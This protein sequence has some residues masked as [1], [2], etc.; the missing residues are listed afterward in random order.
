MIKYT[1]EFNESEIKMEIYLDNAAT[2]KMK[3]EGINVMVQAMEK[4]Y[5]NSSSI[6]SKGREAEDALENAR[7]SLAKIIGATRDE[8][9]F[10]SG[11][12]EGNNQ[13]IKNYGKSG[14]H[15]VTTLVEH[16]SVLLSMKE[17]ER[18]GAEVDYLDV[19][20]K[21]HIS[22][23]QLKEK[24]RKN[25]ALV[26]IMMVNNETGMITNLK[27]VVN[28]VRS[29]SKKAKIHVDG[30]QGFLKYPM[31]VKALDL[32]FLTVSAHKV[33]GPKG[34]GFLYVKKGHKP[35]SL[36]H[37][38]AHERRMRAGTVD[39]PGIVAFEQAAIALDSNRERNLNYVLAL[40]TDFMNRLTPIEGVKINSPLDESS[41]YILNVSFIGIRGEILL[42]Y[43]DE[44][45]IYVATGSACTAKDHQ[46][47]HVL[48]AMH[49]DKDRIMGSM[50][51]S[52]SEETTLEEITYTVGII[53]EALHFL[54]RI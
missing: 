37:G 13:I 35:E 1:S 29:L 6:H 39:V 18:N 53:K 22:L 54:R 3:K 17:A 15:L 16:K 45:G 34:L 8:V 31:N 44:K 12:T 11:A 51:F 50:R 40:K 20:E 27:D 23:D 19:D 32:D 26:S 4:C 25:T 49:M 10:N 42:H 36:L 38:G 33:H 47:S 7:E 5:G 9:I 48:E 41:A 30:V 46:G 21:G 2:T 24:V 43:L 28:Q 14:A 52:F